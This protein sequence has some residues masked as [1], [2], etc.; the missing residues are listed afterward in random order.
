MATL[1]L[2]C[3]SEPLERPFFFF[4]FSSSFPPTF[5]IY[6]YTL[7]SY[8]KK[9]SFNQYFLI[10]LIYHPS[11]AVHPVLVSH[12]ALQSSITSKVCKADITPEHSYIRM[13]CHIVLSQ[14]AFIFQSFTVSVAR[15][16]ILGVM[17]GENLEINEMVL[18]LAGPCCASFV[19]GVL[20]QSYTSTAQ[21]RVDKISR[22]CF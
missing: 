19:R 20:T 17:G 3:Y 21:H 13:F 10:N 6:L 7:Q 15:E 11:L 22:C 16:G 8:H 5:K 4:F 2:G 18:N 9:A 14:F 12:V 1:C